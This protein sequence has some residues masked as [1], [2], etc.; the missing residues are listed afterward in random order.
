MFAYLPVAKLSAQFVAGLG[1]SKI[2]ADI[3]KNNVT[4]AT[5]A[6]SVTVKAGSIVLGSMLVEQSSNHIERITN[7]VVAWFEKRNTDNKT[8]K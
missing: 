2:L 5:T 3:V 8:Q 6:Q 1:V 4:I 7:E